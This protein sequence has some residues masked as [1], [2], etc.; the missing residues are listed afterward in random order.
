MNRNF[1]SPVV[2]TLHLAAYVVNTL[3]W[4][5]FIFVGALARAAIPVDAW[6]K[7]W[8]RTLNRFAENW[9]WF[10]NAFHR[11]ASDTKWHVEGVEP[12]KRSDW[13]LVIANHQSW[14]DILVLQK[15][16]HRKIPFLKF[17]I[18]KELFWF[19]VL[20][21]AWW[22]LDFPFIKRYPKSVLKKKPH[23]VGQD[24]ETTRKA[25]EK[26]KQVPISIMNFVEGTRFT[27]EKKLRQ[28]SPYENLLR[29]KAGGI[30]FVIGAMGGQIRRVLDVTIVYSEGPKSFWAFLCGDIKEIKVLV[31]SFPIDENMVGDY[32]TNLKFRIR[33]QKWLNEV[34][35]EK[36]RYI[37]RIAASPR[38]EN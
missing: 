10:N 15:V 26:F 14:T 20:G 8:G 18:K 33:F 23:L 34:W 27:P 17:F 1:L 36:D 29:A 38:L 11:L 7:W 3:F 37:G 30:A 12:L 32:A 5:V 25:C 35:E 2:G 16:F 4:C 28:K 6:Q 31:K 21:Q 19:P 24:M 13:Y 22:A 9:I